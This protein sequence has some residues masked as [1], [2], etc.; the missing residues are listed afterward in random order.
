MLFDM[1]LNPKWLIPAAWVAAVHYGGGE[2][3]VFGLA[4]IC[5]DV[6]E[7]RK[8]WEVDGIAMVSYSCCL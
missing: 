2:V 5:G 1:R 3:P 6:L 4:L 7:V 8:A